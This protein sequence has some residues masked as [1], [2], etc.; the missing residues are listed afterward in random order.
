MLLA[1]NG[2]AVLTAHIVNIGR[3]QLFCATSDMQSHNLDQYC[4]SPLMTH[5]ATGSKLYDTNFFDLHEI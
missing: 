3:T 4:V 2:E 1:W 5:F